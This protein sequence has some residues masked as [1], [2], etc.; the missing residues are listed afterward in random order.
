[1]LRGSGGLR[2]VGRARGLVCGFG[3]EVHGG[4]VCARVLIGLAGL[5]VICIMSVC[6]ALWVGRRGAERPRAQDGRYS[7]RVEK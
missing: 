2:G 1:M 6:R 5:R 4:G 7:E 3:V